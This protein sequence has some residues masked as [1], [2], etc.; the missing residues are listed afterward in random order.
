MGVELCMQETTIN[1]IINYGT[2]IKM[3]GRV[4]T[5]CLSRH[6]LNSVTPGSEVK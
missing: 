5:L 3:G 4:V 6:H 2:L 1:A